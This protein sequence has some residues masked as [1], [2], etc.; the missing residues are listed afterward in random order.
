MLSENWTISLSLL[1]DI[2]ETLSYLEVFAPHF[3]QPCI[4]TFFG[5]AVTRPMSL[6]DGMARHGPPC[7]PTRRIILYESLDIKESCLCT[8]LLMFRLHFWEQDAEQRFK[9]K[10]MVDI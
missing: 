3:G 7:C 8:T 1:F 5:E 10:E 9:D 4:H 6:Q 2:H